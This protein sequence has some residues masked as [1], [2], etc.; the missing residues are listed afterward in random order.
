MIMASMRNWLHGGPLEGAAAAA[1]QG[2]SSS[3]PAGKRVVVVHCKA[4]KGRSGTATC[5]YLIAEEGWGLD[6]ALARFTERRMRPRFGP[7]VSIPSQLR[8]VGYVDRWTRHG[9]KY[10]D[11]AIDV[12]EVHV[13]GLCNGIKV[14][15]KGF[16][17]NGRKICVF[18]TFSRTERVVVEGN[19]PGGGGLG[20][21]VWDWAG[22][23]SSADDLALPGDK[24]HQRLKRKGTDLIQR[25]SAQGS[26]PGL[27]QRKSKTCVEL[28]TAAAATTSSSDVRTE[29]PDDAEPGG[30]AVV[31]KPTEPIR[32]PTS[33]INISVE[34]R[35]KTPKS[36]GLTM[37]T[38]V[39]H[40]WFNAFFEDRGAEQGGRP[41]DSGVFAIDWDAMEGI[42]GS[43]RKGSRALDRLAVVWRAA[44]AAAGE[45]IVEPPEGQPVPQLQAA[46]W[47]GGNAEGP[48]AE[49]DL[50]LRVQSPASADVSRASSFRS[51]EG[52]SRPR[53]EGGGGGGDDDDDGGSLAG[54]RCS[55]PAG[56]ELLDEAKGA[57]QRG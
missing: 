24:R 8:W 35:N 18:H 49:P 44:R 43:S 33:D 15:V 20:Q 52:V 12:V 31:L 56:E 29:P 46:D 50:G 23:P 45:E 32:L 26:R 55:G 39:A 25:V 41:N 48:R 40:V 4:G 27:D 57:V 54:V 53:D 28:S 10:V 19:P 6:D 42:K 14:D 13:W 7:G 36:M 51:A 3:P 17:D 47:A 37:V 2:S 11:R 34:R 22:Y 30:M 21:M 5:S 9:K 16:V 1:R 38:A